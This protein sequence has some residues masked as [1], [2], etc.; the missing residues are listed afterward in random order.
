MARDSTFNRKVLAEINLTGCPVGTVL[1]KN[2][3]DQSIEERYF[4]DWSNGLTAPARW[5]MPS[6]YRV[7]KDGDKE[8]LE[9]INKTDRCLVT[10]ERLWGD[11]SVEAHIRQLN[12]F[13][14]PSN[15]DPHAIV[16]RSGLMFRYQ[17]LRRYY[18]FCLEGFERFVL[19]RHEDEAWTMLADLVNG[20]DRARYYHLKAV[21][22]GEGI[23]CYV[24]GKK[25]FVAYDD[26]FPT[27]KV[28]VRTN[29]RSRTYGVRVT[30]SEEAHSVYVNR[31][32]DYEREVAEVSEK[33]PKP[34]LWKRIDISAYWPCS[35]RY[36]DFRG[37][38][39]K[40]IV[41][42]K[43]TAEGPRVIVLDLDGEVQW[44]KVYPAAAELKRT[45]VHDLDGDGVEDIIGIEGDLLRMVS[46]KTGEITAETQL[47]KTGPYRGFRDVSIGNYLHSLKVLW[48]CHIRKTEKAQDLI[49]RDGDG[50]GTGYSI[51]AFDEKL[52][53]RW[54]QD[55]HNSWYG[56]YIWFCDV[57]GD[58][59][60]EILPGYDLYDGDGNH[61]WTME[62]SEY[63]EDSGGAGHIDHAAFGE[64]DGD[65]GNGPE[66]GIAGSDPG[67]FLV[68]ARTG[69]LLA[70]HRFGHVQGIYAGN[71]R[72]D[73]PGLEMWMGD[74]WGTYGILNLV[75]GKGRPLSR[76]E[77]DN[78]SQG[79]PAVNWSGDGEEL[80]FISTTK[81]AFGFYDAECRKVL[82]PVP[83]GLPLE[84][85]GGIVEDVVGDSRDEITFVHEGSVYIVTQDRDYP[86]GEKIYAPTRRKDISIPGWRIN[87]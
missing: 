37:A 26:V 56:M 41:L 44:D 42:E 34:V 78:V 10:G 9:H 14:E 49:L 76:F 31:L 69:V 63:I 51:W 82:S 24:D 61:L 55:A 3:P 83:E 68:D 45:A 19:Y 22:N 57:D 77:P 73:L 86:K 28:G 64:L 21:C 66:I 84:W 85:G 39:K 87:E 12:A 43:E 13:T 62:G 38:G 80:L 75:S 15:D 20:I 30:T 53:L 1:D 74:R 16:S 60:D 29:T 6:C 54:R 5:E 46:G 58:G 7:V 33:Y 18:Y 50:A 79:G 8:V 48:P 2:D 72:P 27:G 67:F 59:R 81:E 70:H 35:F 23:A 52:N 25:V 4:K 32:S 17:D 47:P 40:E 65:E 36:G 71:F 11:Y